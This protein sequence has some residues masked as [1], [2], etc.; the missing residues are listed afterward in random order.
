MSGQ[1]EAPSHDCDGVWARFT[2]LCQALLL[3]CNSL[4]GGA[5]KTTSEIGFPAKLGTCRRL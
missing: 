2:R 1:G 5:D 3:C 4:H